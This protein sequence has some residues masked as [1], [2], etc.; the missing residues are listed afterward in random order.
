MAPS[1]AIDPRAANV[2]SEAG[3]PLR[4]VVEHPAL[5]HYRVP[6]FRAIAARPGVRLHVWYGD[7]DPTLENVSPD[8]FEATLSPVRQVRL[9]RLG[10]LIWHPAQ[11]STATRDDADVLVLAANT[12]YLSLVPG[13]LRAR[14]AGIPTVVWGHHYSKAPSAWRD[15]TRRSMTRLA[16]AVLTYDART[17]A[18]L[19]AAGVPERKVFVAANGL[20]RAPIDAARREWLDAPG[21][22]EAFRAERLPGPGPVLI[23]T[24]RLYA[25]NR[26]DVAVE[27]LAHLRRERPDARLVVVGEGEPERARLEAV[28]RASGVADAI[29]WAGAIFDEAE[30]A[31]WMLSA[32]VSVYPTNS[33]LSI[34]HA[35]N[36]GVPVVVAAP[37]ERHNPEIMALEDGVNGLVAES[38]DPADFAAACARPLD[39]PALRARLSQAAL[40]TA[41]DSFNIEAMATSMVECFRL[42]HRRAA[43]QP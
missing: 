5:P 18:A 8:G 19:V 32:D 14:R 29:V 38:L 39:D 37:L 10:P 30:I 21:R 42:L 34:V 9:P 33:G 31:P 24:G 4:V 25:D 7:E 6:L 40:E 20:D 36:Y 28:A 43:G 22:L 1:P 23:F 13:L 35:F 12:R 16:D 3:D 11:W 27:A 17:A 26:L 2:G 41:R 15:A